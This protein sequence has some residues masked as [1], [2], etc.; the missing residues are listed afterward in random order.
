[1]VL[2][3]CSHGAQGAHMVHQVPGASSPVIGACICMPPGHPRPAR[4]TH[5][6]PERC[7]G[8]AKPCGTTHVAEVAEVAVVHRMR[9]PYT[10]R[11][12]VTGAAA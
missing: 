4:H 2:T 9:W 8:P 1:M 7:I 6:G 3:W 10:W 5:A 11:P 12:A